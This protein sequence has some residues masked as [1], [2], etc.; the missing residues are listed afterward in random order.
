MTTLGFDKI[1]EIGSYLDKRLFTEGI[2]KSK[3]DIYVNNKD[4][5]KKIDEDL[6]Y[7]QH[8]NGTD[9]SPSDD[10]ITINFEHVIFNISVKDEEKKDNSESK[11]NTQTSTL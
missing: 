2:D 6:Y 7:R 10:M 11:E 9:F 1:Y 4:E 5:L 8:P 3:L